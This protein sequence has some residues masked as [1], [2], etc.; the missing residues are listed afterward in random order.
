MSCQV[1]KS[2]RS[3]A[4]IKE[5]AVTR[6][7]SLLMALLTGMLS[8]ALGCPDPKIDTNTPTDDNSG[9]SCGQA[10]GCEP[11]PAAT[12]QGRVAVSSELD[13]SGCSC[14]IFTDYT[15]CASLGQRCEQGACVEP[16][17]ACKDVS[18]PPKPQ[19]CQ[20]DSAIAFVGSGTC[21]IDE[22]GKGV[23]HYE[24]VLRTQSCR[25]LGL[26]CVEG[27]CAEAIDPCDTEE[28]ARPR[29]RCDGDTLVR[30]TGN[31][32]CSSD[33]GEATCDYSRVEERVDC[34]AQSKT[35]VD[36]NCV[37]P[38]DPCDGIACDMPPAA[39]CDMNVAV[40]Y[41]GSGMCDMTDGSCDYT[42]AEV[43][44][45]CAAMGQTCMNGTCIDP[46]NPCL[47]VTCDMPPAA[48]CDVNVAVTY[49]GDG[50]CD[51]TDGGCDYS[52]AQVRT[53]C[54]AMG[55]TCMNG[56]CIDPANPCLNVTCD[57][58]P[59]ASCNA[60]V[61]V[62]YSGNGMCDMTD[63]SC[64]YSGAEQQTDCAMT[65]Q[66]CMNGMCVDPADPC[67][68]VT[69]DMPPAAS[70]DMNVAVTYSGNGTCDMTDGSCD[71]AT[72]EVRTDCA[73][74]AQV[75]MN[76]ACVAPANLCMNVTCDMPPAAS[77]AMNVA[78][79]YSGNGTCN[80]ADGS[81]D[82]TTAEVRTDC[83]MTAQTCMNGTCQ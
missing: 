75:C 80:M 23:C 15:D 71:Y 83:A 70:C 5:H 19:R 81:C 57:M 26:R 2:T 45:D 74:T 61:A 53:D 56:M 77:C 4:A 46:A 34:A 49:S 9:S 37:D 67:L 8:F 21:K 27:R 82:Y 55:Q 29:R 62:T 66:V 14:A 31:G 76:G 63:G 1:K 41:S 54:A 42:T 68:N 38:N 11:A 73:M 40:T 44:T 35:C 48:S 65:G 3:T 36:G 22:D 69:C 52:G 7:S 47:N 58:P 24:D 50:A 51:M 16:P 32:L 17:A 78:V 13:P 25:A 18:C 72:A 12:C 59:A 20:G 30:H 28:C 79:T 43:R 64:D 33:D 60:N 39:S 10:V 6:R